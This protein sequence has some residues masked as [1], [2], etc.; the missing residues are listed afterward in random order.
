MTPNR[1][2]PWPVW[3]G[4]RTVWR[5]MDPRALPPGFQGMGVRIMRR[6]A[7]CEEADCQFIQ[8]GWTQAP[9]GPFLGDQT[10]QWGGVYHPAGVPCPVAHKVPADVPPIFLRNGSPIAVGE[11]TERL[12]EGVEAVIHVR[13]HGL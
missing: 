12:G 9:G 4:H 3:D 13:T 11:F 5:R 2:V 7:T 1:G 8:H 10:E 6:L